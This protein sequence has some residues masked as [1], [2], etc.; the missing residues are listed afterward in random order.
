MSYQRKIVWSDFG[1]LNDF[2][3]T[4]DILKMT[5]VKPNQSSIKFLSPPHYWTDGSGEGDSEWLWRSETQTHSSDQSYPTSIGLGYLVPPY[6][7][8]DRE[9]WFIYFRGSIE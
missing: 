8:V 7:S 2:E 4:L 6:S 9:A 3:V 1:L 5:V